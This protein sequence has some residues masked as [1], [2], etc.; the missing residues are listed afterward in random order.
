MTSG[1]I[2]EVNYYLIPGMGA[3]QRLFDRF[4]LKYGQVNKLNWIPHQNSRNLADY[5]RLMAERITTENNVLVGSSMGGMVA[6]EMS[7]IINPLATV[8]VSAPTG[9][10]QFPQI[11][12]TFDFIKL[13]K[14]LTPSQIMKIAGL[15]DLF[16]GFKTPEQ[17]AM[18]YDMLKNNGPEFLHFS[19]DAVLG[20][21]NTEPPAGDFIQ[22]I[23]TVDKLFRHDKIANAIALSG[24]G[25]FAAFE[26]GE[27]ISAI[28]NEYIGKKII[29]KDETL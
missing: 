25:H 14:A 7:R 27:E 2:S 18:F 3:D 15:A 26:A 21:K 10:H 22:V 4:D 29:R 11:L 9:R 28:I 23:G 24:K 8:L 19:V 1:N 16:M 6:V 13:H 12:K 20:W 5:A 17:R